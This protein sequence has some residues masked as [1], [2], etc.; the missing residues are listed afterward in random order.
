MLRRLLT[1]G[2]RQ[3]TEIVGTVVRKWAL[4]DNSGSRNLSLYNGT[5]VEDTSKIKQIKNLNMIE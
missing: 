4:R 1:K 3:G 2:S 5:E